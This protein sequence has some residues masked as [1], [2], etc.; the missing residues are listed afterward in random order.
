MREEEC[1]NIDV[2][3]DGPRA[4]VTVGQHSGIWHRFEDYPTVDELQSVVRDAWEA[5]IEAQRENA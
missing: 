2:E 1:F 5:D 3:A 4:I